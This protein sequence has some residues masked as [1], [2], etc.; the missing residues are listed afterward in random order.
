MSAQPFR[1][2]E[3]ESPAIPLLLS[4]PHCATDFPGEMRDLYIDEL[5]EAPDDTDWYLDIL[6]DFA[7]SLG[8]TTIRPS[9]SRWVIDLNREPSSKPLYNDGRI[10]TALCPTT[11]FSGRPIYVD[12]RTELEAHDIEQRLTAL[13]YPYHSEIDRILKRFAAEFGVA[14]LWDGHSIRR[15][16]PSIH[17]EPFPDLILGDNE[18]GSADGELIATALTA[19]KSGSYS[20]AHNSPF[21]GGYLTRSKGDPDQNIHALQLEM[22]KDLYMSGDETIYSEECAAPV[23]E[24]LKQVFGKVIQG[25]TDSAR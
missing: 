3:P 16:V 15:H 21:K 20:V 14:L 18:G 11:D 23:K 7:P 2:I 8:V 10:L 19:L 13:F 24:H 1:I 25:L 17:K 9:F 5:A 12:G 22:S 6:Y 4:L